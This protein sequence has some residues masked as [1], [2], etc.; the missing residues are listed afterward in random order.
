MFCPC[1]DLLN[2]AAT[3]AALPEP[4]CPCPSRAAGSFFDPETDVCA[5]R[6]AINLQ[7]SGYRARSVGMT[8]DF[9]RR[10]MTFSSL[11]LT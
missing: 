8:L 5:F 2:P 7:H 4:Q 3:L 9:R 1:R 10:D 11:G 6:R